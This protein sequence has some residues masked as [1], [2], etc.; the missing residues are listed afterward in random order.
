MFSGSANTPLALPDEEADEGDAQEP[1][2][3][4]EGDEDERDVVRVLQGEET[5]EAKLLREAIARASAVDEKPAEAERVKWSKI[6]DRLRPTQAALGYDWCFYKLKNLI[7]EAAAQRYMDSKPVPYVQRGKNKYVVDHHHTL[8]ALELFTR[9]TGCD[10]TITLER[11]RSFD[12]TEQNS[13]TDEA[14]WGLMEGKGWAFLRD[15]N[16]NRSS[17]GSLPKDFAL[18]SF[19]NDVYRS[20]GGFA[21]VYDVLKRGKELEDLLF[22]EF[23]WG[24]FFWLHRNDSFSLWPDKRLL[25]AFQRCV[26]LVSE[27]DTQEYAADAKANTL[28]VKDCIYLSTQVIEPA[29]QVLSFYLRNLAIEYDNLKG[30]ERTVAGLGD[31]FGTDTLPGKVVR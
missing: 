6:K 2:S 22:F 8:A 24:F 12:K 7:S 29:Y 30:K 28:K 16:Y 17:T 3:D 27:I 25:R 11:I 31:L 10:V 26:A 15:E 13:L 19:R 23:R 1:D 21:R 18:S 4:H 5:F 9:S 20:M 14:F